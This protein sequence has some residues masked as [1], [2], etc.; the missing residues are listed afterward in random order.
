MC[1]KARILGEMPH[2]KYIDYPNVDDGVRGMKF[3]YAVIKSGK[4]TDKW[5]E[6]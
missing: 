5:T 6:L 3:V 2:D 4:S 1:I